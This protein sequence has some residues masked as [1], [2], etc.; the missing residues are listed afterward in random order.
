MKFSA[1]TF[2]RSEES[3]QH[4]FSELH[5]VSNGVPKLSIEQSLELFDGRQRAEP[6]VLYVND[7]SYPHQQYIADSSSKIDR[8]RSMKRSPSC[9]T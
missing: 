6:F 7:T 4:N 9:S 8:E 3:V 1:R 5:I 2:Q